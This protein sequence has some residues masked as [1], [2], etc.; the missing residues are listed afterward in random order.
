MRL[1][2][3]KGIRMT[4]NDFEVIADVLKDQRNLAVQ[5]GVDPTPAM[6]AAAFA[7]RLALINPRFNRAK[8]LRA[9]G[10]ETTSPVA[11]R[12]AHI[13]AQGR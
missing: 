4:R 11:A 6:I 12:T 13:R 7:D 9:C 5:T 1:A 3:L 2:N 8:F 10:V